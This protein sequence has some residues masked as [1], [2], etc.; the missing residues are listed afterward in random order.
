VQ[1]WIFQA[2]PQRNDINAALRELSE[3]AWRVPQ[4]TGEIHTGDIVAI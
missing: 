4:L 3:I 2:N 1:H